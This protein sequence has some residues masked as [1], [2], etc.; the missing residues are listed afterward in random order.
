MFRVY[1]E[2]Y[3]ENEN[4]KTQFEKNYK[5]FFSNSETGMGLL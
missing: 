4:V 3:Y 1:S 2:Y 5:N